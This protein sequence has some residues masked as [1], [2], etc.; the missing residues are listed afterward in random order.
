[1]RNWRGLKK[2]LM[3]L[4]RNNFMPAKRTE[5]EKLE[6]AHRAFIAEVQANVEE[7]PQEPDGIKEELH[8]DDDKLTEST[9]INLI[10]ASEVDPYEPLEQVFETRETTLRAAGTELEQQISSANLEECDRILSAGNLIENRLT[11]AE[12]GQFFSGRLAELLTLM[13]ILKANDFQ[14]R[15][16]FEKWRTYLRQLVSAYRGFEQERFELSEWLRKKTEERKAEL[17]KAGGK[18]ARMRREALKKKGEEWDE[19]QIKKRV[20]SALYGFDIAEKSA[21]ETEKEVGDAKNQFARALAA[22]RNKVAAASLKE[23]AD[24]GKELDNTIEKWDAWYSHIDKSA[25]IEL[26][27]TLIDLQPRRG[28][29]DE[30]LDY[31]RRFTNQLPNALRDIGHA[32]DDEVAEARAAIENRQSALLKAEDERAWREGGK[33]LAVKR[34][35]VHV[36]DAVQ[37]RTEAEKETALQEGK[38]WRDLPPGVIAFRGFWRAVN[39]AE[40][41]FEKRSADEITRWNEKWKTVID[42]YVSKLDKPFTPQEIENALSAV[43]EERA[44]KNEPNRHEFFDYLE[45][46]RRVPETRKAE[47][48]T[49]QREREQWQRQQ[50]LAWE[51]R[52]LGFGLAGAGE[53]AIREQARQARSAEREKERREMTQ[54]KVNYIARG[55][56]FALAVAWNKG[57][58]QGRADIQNLFKEHDERKWKE[59]LRT[60]YLRALED[61]GISVPGREYL[62]WATGQREAKQEEEGS[63]RSLDGRSAVELAS[64]AVSMNLHDKRDPEWLLREGRVQYVLPGQSVPGTVAINTGGRHGDVFEDGQE[65]FLMEGAPRIPRPKPG[66]AEALFQEYIGLRAKGK[67]TNF[68]FS[69]V[70]LGQLTEFLDHHDI[71]SGKETAGTKFLYEKLSALGAFDKMPQEERQALERAIEYVVWDDNMAHPKWREGNWWEEHWAEDWKKDPPPITLLHLAKQVNLDTL[72]RFYKKYADNPEAETRPLTAEDL[73]E[74][75]ELKGAIKEQ[76]ETVRKSTESLD[77]LERAGFVLDT[78]AYGTLVIR[79]PQLEGKYQKG[80]QIG[81]KGHVASLPGGI[82]AVRAKYGKDSAL[83]VWNPLA[84]KGTAFFSTAGTEPLPRF[85]PFEVGVG[86]RVRET[87]WLKDPKHGLHITLRDFLKSVL[88]DES[89]GYSFDYR[90]TRGKLRDYLDPFDAAKNLNPRNEVGQ[91]ELMRPQEVE[92]VD[93]AE[94]LAREVPEL[95]G[96]V[97]LEVDRFGNVRVPDDWTGGKDVIVE[98]P[99]GFDARTIL[100]EK[101]YY[102]EVARM[103]DDARY[104]TRVFETKLQGELA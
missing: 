94:I 82:E 8:E 60:L 73:Q 47:R 89:R 36:D 33:D 54:E 43:R 103:V 4:R 66:S 45:A 74:F 75:P 92:R 61:Q 15:T 69:R 24:L 46:M 20:A 72:T 97:P 91:I 18:K 68:D 38:L 100:E 35:I 83:M 31:W 87:M 59:K 63:A 40:H 19:G 14:P 56:F 102:L 26:N 17:E 58:E 48:E 65:R 30:V 39:D 11:G 101:R 85:N 99:E 16:R 70:D 49:R 88:S 7:V 76:Q 104:G 37:S 41:V 57:G 93:N 29:S 21:D 2:I 13:E 12:E 84:G 1:M 78:E 64:M 79:V 50:E 96:P 3:R 98:L 51:M 42:H 6:T 9:L 53:A 95:T 52:N 28:L 90:A 32:M 62:D 71:T 80:Q 55:E 27:A 44:Q 10:K 77:T 34:E 67:H 86:Q 25:L 22:I 5:F 81:W 23:C